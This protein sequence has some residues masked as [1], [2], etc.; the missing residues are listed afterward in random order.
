MHSYWK[1]NKLPSLPRGYYIAIQTVEANTFTNDGMI[2]GILS[3][4]AAISLSNTSLDSVDDLEGYC[5]NFGMA[6][7][8]GAVSGALDVIMNEKLEYVGKEASIGIG[9]GLPVDIHASV[10]KT[11][12][13]YKTNVV[14]SLKNVWKAFQKFFVR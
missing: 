11:T 6:I 9:V 4:G 13:L 8:A 12:T 7:S 3:A 10:S 1:L 5:F 2:I 14:K